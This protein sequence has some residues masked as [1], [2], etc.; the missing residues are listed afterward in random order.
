MKT[1]HI[2]IPVIVMG[3]T[4]LVAVKQAHASEL[5]ST[6]NI[7]LLCIEST[8]S[9]VSELTDKQVADGMIDTVIQVCATGYQV[10][11]ADDEIT[12]ADNLGAFNANLADPKADLNATQRLKDA[13]IIGFNLGVSRG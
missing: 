8:E 9:V 6:D 4:A 12:N 13:Y 7:A 1:Q 5:V 11:Q 3:L 2:V 10:G